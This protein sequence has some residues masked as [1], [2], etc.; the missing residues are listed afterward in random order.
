MPPRHRVAALLACM[1]APVACDS[2]NAGSS[3]ANKPATED[4]RKAPAFKVVAAPN[5]GELAQVIAKHVKE[6]EA[7]GLRP[8]VEFWATWC[9]PCKAI[10]ASMDDPL[11][12]EAFAGTYV[13]RLDSD[14]WGSKLAGT[15][16][17]VASIPVFY[18]LD[19]KGTSTGRKIGGS[20]WGEDT[21]KN[22]APPLREFFQANAKK[23]GS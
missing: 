13:I 17:D 19:A 7:L 16:F 14:H 2:D 6:A 12:K 22:M 1:L 11:M 8:H 9:P 23:P 20:A 15:G 21:P 10:E 18:E 3:S 5:E 4:E